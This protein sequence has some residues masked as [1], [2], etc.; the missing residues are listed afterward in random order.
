MFPN[1]YSD[2]AVRVQPGQ[3]SATLGAIE[4]VWTTW[5][6][7]WPFTYAFLDAAFEA[8]YLSEQKLG[9][10]LLV[11]AMLAL[12]IA[13][14]GLFGLVAYAVD[15]RTKEIGIR[16]VLGATAG[17]ILVR[18]SADFLK[19]VLAAFVLAAPLAYFAMDYW[20]SGFAF[21]TPIGAG[22][23]ALVGGLAVAIALVTIVY[24]TLRAALSDPVKVLRYE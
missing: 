19:L 5:A 22:T 9:Q 23:F 18:L 6:P 1:V 21:R 14:F 24:Q 8:L 10:L 11:F 2:M 3:A 4:E 16:K 20:L 17:S 15:Q 12:L 13:C 7:E